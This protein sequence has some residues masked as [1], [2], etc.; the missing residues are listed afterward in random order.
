[1]PTAPRR[2]Q[3]VAEHTAGNLYSARTLY[4]DGCQG[5]IEAVRLTKD[6]AQYVAEIALH[7]WCFVAFTP[8]R[9]SSGMAGKSGCEN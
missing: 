9:S 7:S 8:S 3:A 2:R 1:M 6:A 4:L 5:L